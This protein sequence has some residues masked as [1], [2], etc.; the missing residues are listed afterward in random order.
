[1]DNKQKKKKLFDFSRHKQRHI[2]LKILYFGWDYYGLAEQN[3]CD[4]TIE[5][6]LF[7]ALRITCLIESRQQCNYN[8]CGRTDKGV[9]SYGQ[10]VN[11]DVR[12]NLVD[13]KD[14][15]NLGL[16]TPEGYIG[17]PSETGTSDGTIKE[18]NYIDTLNRVLPDHIRAIAWTPVG[19][20]FSARFDCQ[21]RSYSYLFPKGDLNIE[22]MQSSLQYLVGEHD[23]R[24]LCSFDLK[25]GVINHTRTILEAHLHPIKSI[26]QTQDNQM[27]TQYEFYEVIIVGKAFLYHQIRCIMSILF[28]VGTR[29]EHPELFRDL[30]DI[31][32]CP[33]RPNYNRASPLPLSLFDC[34]Y[35]E[36]S[37]PFKW[38]YDNQALINVYKNLK[39]LWL[40]YRTKAMMIERVLKDFEVELLKEDNDTQRSQTNR[41]KDFGLTF[42]T[43]SDN[44]Y[45]DMMKR[46]RD[47]TLE[48]KL[49]KLES[50]L[51]SSTHDA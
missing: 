41:W 49:S 43:M 11:L 3:N 5:H 37:M 46:P 13:E 44:K 25:N 27:T 34:Q 51:A 12:S 6:H 14:P 20:T 29:K 47:E 15:N 30:L 50:K 32:K 23:F 8:R 24:N 36:E 19:P 28:L 4:N 1:M 21:S 7:E 22:A 35:S 10:V 40:T 2:G 31:N 45:I 39:Q 48:S 18:I 38:N 16:F 9:S 33:S 26:D 17:K 42:D